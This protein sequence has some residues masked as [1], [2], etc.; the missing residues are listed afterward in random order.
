MP[1]AELRATYAS[2]RNAALSLATPL[3]LPPAASPSPAEKAAYLGDLRAAAAALQ[4]R[5][6]GELTAQMEEDK[7]REAS[8]AGGGGGG[9]GR[10]VVAAEAGTDRGEGGKSGSGGG[11]GGGGGA[12]GGAKKAAK[13]VDEDAEEENYGEEVVEDD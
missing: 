13:D 6:N 8:A 3:D 9:S 2:P 1:R 4:E 11:G 10:G 5:I 12:G 7:A